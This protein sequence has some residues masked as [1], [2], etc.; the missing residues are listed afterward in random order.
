MKVPQL[1][2]LYDKVGFD[3]TQTSNRAGFGFLHDGSVDS[4][5]RFVS[6]PLFTVASDQD[7]AD[8]V[9]FLLA[10]SGG[11]SPVGDARQPSRAARADGARLPRGRR[12]PGD[13]RGPGPARRCS[14]RS[15]KR[16]RRPGA[17]T[18]S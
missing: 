16:R 1:R 5:A 17:S 12:A 18:S 3:L 4:L 10:F 15:S 11:G 14:R 2:N 6:E 13:A 8:L 9:A 7:V